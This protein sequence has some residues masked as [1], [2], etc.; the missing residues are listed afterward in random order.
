MKILVL[1]D[2]DGTLADSA[3]DLAHSANTLRTA[4][5][6]EPLSVD[7]LRPYASMGAR[8]LIWATLGLKP[9]DPGYQEAH[10]RFLAHYQQHLDVDTVLFEGMGALLDTLNKQQIPWGVVTNKAEHLTRPIMQHLGIAQ[11]CAVLV[12]G[13]STPYL[14]PHPAALFRAAKLFNIPTEQCLYIGDDK[15]DIVAA[16]AADMGTVVAAYGYCQF[17]PET[18]TW[19]ADAIVNHANEIYPVVK[20]WAKKTQT[21]TAAAL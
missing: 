17:S 11:H 1:F 2:F 13:D 14:K 12:G 18:K 15:R 7:Y 21:K 10:Q 8:G 4:Q 19:G 5:G 3:P 20:Q 9:D 16:Q 6:L